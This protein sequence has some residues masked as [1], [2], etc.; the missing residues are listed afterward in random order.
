MSALDIVA[1]TVEIFS[2]HTIKKKETLVTSHTIYIKRSRNIINHYHGVA[3]LTS[4]ISSI[5]YWLF[6]QVFF[7][8][9]L[10]L[11]STEAVV[12]PTNLR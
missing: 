10:C 2:L 1:K 4:K 7:T 5:I 9:L 8:C 6:E 11:G 3:N 12:P